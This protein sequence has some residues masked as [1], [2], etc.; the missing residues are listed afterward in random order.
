MEKELAQ[1][2]RRGLEY[3]L[4]QC[5]VYDDDIQV[6]TAIIID[7]ILIE[8]EKGEEL[9]EAIQR[10]LVYG[11]RRC[12]VYEDDIVAFSTIIL[13]AVSLEVDKIRRQEPKE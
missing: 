4:F 6:F 9:P 12:K 13:D 8:I 11:L 10:G 7:A 1:A 3:G 2:I 5:K